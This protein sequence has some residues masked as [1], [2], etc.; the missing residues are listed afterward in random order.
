MNI[1]TIETGYA[2]IPLHTPF[3]TALR[4]VTTVETIV[5]KV[6]CDNGVIGWGEAPPTEVITGDS[7][8]SIVEAINTMIKPLL[9]GQSLLQREHVFAALSSSAVG[10][11]SAK[12]AV[13]MALHDCLAQYAGMPLFQFLGGY[14]SVIETDDTVSVNHP[15]EMADDAQA[16]I[17]DGFTT[18]KVKV[19]RDDS[20][21]DI[22][23]IEAIRE[24]V[25]PDPL[26]RLD[27]NQGWQA[28]EAVRTIQKM[29]TLGLD[30]QCVEQ[31]VVRHDLD[32]LR[33]V[34]AHT[35]PL[36]VAD[37]SVFSAYDAKRVLEARAVD[38]INIKLMK[39]GGIHEAL[40]V[41]TLADI[42]GVACMVGSMMETGMGITAAAHVAASQPN[43]TWYD[44]DAPLML[45]GDTIDGGIEYN[46]SHI[47][48]GNRPGL[49]ITGLNE[50]VIQWHQD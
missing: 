50:R 47:T 29:E 8:A 33:Y 21:T 11:T 49:G 15:G 19:G 36:I 2:S 4:T 5:V 18:L 42:Y 30:I 23:R 43:V 48:F 3:K 34:T 12:A 27:A 24:Q 38:M 40:K 10:N 37:E 35:S 44:L 25:G 7:V 39:T 46:A 32:G 17:N 26:I 31:P 13:D 45:D 14:R 28:K 1:Q 9:C 22:K 16:C 6:T 41:A 20:Q